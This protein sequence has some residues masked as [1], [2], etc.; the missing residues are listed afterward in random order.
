M[1]CS[2]TATHV[3]NYTDVFTFSNLNEAGILPGS[4]C[5]V[6][7]C[8]ANEVIQSSTLYV[9]TPEK[10]CTIQGEVL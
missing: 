4:T 1:N 3:P 8:Y 6:T 9:R 5:F 2:D 7:G 10:N